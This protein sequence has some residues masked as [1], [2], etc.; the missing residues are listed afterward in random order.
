[1][2]ASL[3]TIL[4]IVCGLTASW[5][6]PPARLR[7]PV[8]LAL[9]PDGRWLFTA[10]QRSGSVSVVNTTGLKLIGEVDVGRKLSDLIL[11]SDGRHLLAVDEEA[12]ELIVLARHE[13]RIKVRWRTPVPPGPVGVQTCSDG[14]KCIVA[15]MWPSRRALP[16]RPRYSAARSSHSWMRTAARSPLGEVLQARDQKTNKPV[17]VRVLSQTAMPSLPVGTHE[18]ALGIK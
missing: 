10:N 13:D 18:A 12:S 8:A 2:R 9:T 1:M 16:S 3:I 5:D 7:Y 4:L 14:A 11:T 6:S 17:A 15:S